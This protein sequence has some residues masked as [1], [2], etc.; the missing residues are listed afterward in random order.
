MQE[1]AQHSNQTIHEQLD[2]TE[3][4]SLSV[5]VDKLSEKEIRKRIARTKDYNDR[6]TPE[7]TKAMNAKRKTTREQ[8][9]EN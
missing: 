9:N 8:A 1:P 7:Y 5:Q 2:G 4:S 6:R 3:K